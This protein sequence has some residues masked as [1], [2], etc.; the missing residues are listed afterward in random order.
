MGRPPH[1]GGKALK[2]RYKRLCSGILIL[3]YP[4]I[5]K[6]KKHLHNRLNRVWASIEST[7]GSGA[8]LG[9]NIVR[10]KSLKGTVLHVVWYLQRF[11]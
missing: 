4:T 11:C 6:T 7:A 9:Y 5:T 8:T 10:E 2:L 1:V 3:S